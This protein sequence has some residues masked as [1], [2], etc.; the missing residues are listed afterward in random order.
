MDRRLSLRREIQSPVFFC[1]DR[2][3]VKTPLLADTAPNLIEARVKSINRA[4]LPGASS[5]L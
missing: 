3:H 1:D 4:L 2:D 5:A